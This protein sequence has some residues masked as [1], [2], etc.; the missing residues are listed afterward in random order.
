[1]ILSQY[2]T[3][4]TRAASWLAGSGLLLAGLLALPCRAAAAPPTAAEQRRIIGQLA[5]RYSDYARRYRGVFSRRKVLVRGYDVSSGKLRET[6]A[7]RRDYFEYL[8]KAPSWRT[9]SCQVDGKPAPVKDCEPK[10]GV[11]PMLQP[12][13]PGWD[14]H[15][16]LSIVGQRMVGQ[17]LCH[18]VQVSPLKRSERHFSGKLYVAKTDLRLMLLEGKIA[19]L[20]FPIKEFWTKVYFDKHPGQPKYV[21]ATKGR[22]RLRIKVPLVLHGRLVIDF[23][24]WGHRFLPR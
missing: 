2:H 21:V 22:V 7:A 24:A 20:P 11:K 3:T 5:A 8:D 23:T 18:T 4:L 15:Y 14:K 12:L 1:M 9:V 19:R 10:G 13:A 6:K 16:R 17:T